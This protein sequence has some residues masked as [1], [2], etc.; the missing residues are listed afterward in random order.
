MEVTERLNM[1]CI[2]GCLGFF[3]GVLI[4]GLL[5]N[6]IGQAALALIIVLLLAGAAYIYY[7]NYKISKETKFKQVSLLSDATFG[8]ALPEDIASQAAA[9]DLLAYDDAFKWRVVRSE[10]YAEN[11]EALLQEY[12]GR[13]GEVVEEF[14]AQ[15]V[16][17]PANPLN[18]NAI[19]VSWGGRI[20]G[21]MAKLETPALFAYI[22][23]TGG[24]AQARGRL[25]FG[26]AENNNK[27]RL[28]I[29]MP[30]SPAPTS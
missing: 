23:N 9:T 21:Y 16:C 8:T 25:T 30:F 19:V 11:F 29:A 26:I 24:M 15:L 1:G 13:D 28:D 7:A 27:V 14:Q 6:A 22:M 18:P 17:E 12:E 2:K 3:V 20:I 10:D 4:I 5:A